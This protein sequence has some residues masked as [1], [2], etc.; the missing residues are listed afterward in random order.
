MSTTYNAPT[1]KC[2]CT[3]FRKGHNLGPDLDAERVAAMVAQG[4]DQWAASRVV[5][6]GERAPRPLTPEETPRWV[7]LSLLAR[8]PWL[9][10]EP[11]TGAAGDG[12]VTA[13]GCALAIACLILI[14]AVGR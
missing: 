14:A 1:A 4:I 13:V 9:R 10:L 5:Y 12:L 6:G 11:E 8:L 2:T 3:A 7:R